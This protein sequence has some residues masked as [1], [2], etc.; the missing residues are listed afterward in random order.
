M[1]QTKK[2]SKNI[3]DVLRTF[4]FEKIKKIIQES[5]VEDIK[6]IENSNV[7]HYEFADE[8]SFEDSISR[9]ERSIKYFDISALFELLKINLTSNSFDNFLLESIDD[10][11][12]ILIDETISRFL[13]SVIITAKALTTQIIKN[14]EAW[15]DAIKTERLKYKVV[16]SQLTTII[17][18]VNIEEIQMMNLPAQFKKIKKELK[19]V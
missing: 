1:S 7:E 17:N 14:S 5:R 6:H 16:L 13:I 15:F 3:R 4:K 19:K 12:M 9:Y 2:S 8:E 18:H 11:E 10:L